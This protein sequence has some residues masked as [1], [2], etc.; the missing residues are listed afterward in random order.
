MLRQLLE[1][2]VQARRQQRRVHRRSLERRAGPLLGRRQHL[3]V[4]PAQQLDL[5]TQRTEFGRG[6]LLIALGGPDPLVERG[7]PRALVAQGGLTSL[8][9]AVGLFQTDVGFA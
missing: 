8:V 3:G 7:G 6:G 5:L 4:L 9:L 1:G 2:L